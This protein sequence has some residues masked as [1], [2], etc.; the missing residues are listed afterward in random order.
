MFLVTRNGS[1]ASETCYQVEKPSQKAISFFD[2]K[3]IYKTN[4]G[5]RL[6]PSYSC[7]KNKDFNWLIQSFLNILSLHIFI[8][9][10]FYTTTALKRSGYDIKALLRQ[11]AYVNDV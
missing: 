10:T 11:E 5:D 3:N 2:T 8:D 4:Y 7:V 1:W 6:N 9:G